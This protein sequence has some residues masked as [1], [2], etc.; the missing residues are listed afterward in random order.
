MTEEVL[1]AQDGIELD[2]S[3]FEGA[4]ETNEPT[5]EQKRF[6]DAE[7]EGE[8][9]FGN[10]DVTPA[11]YSIFAEE[12]ENK[13]AAL[14]QEFFDKIVATDIPFA[15]VEVAHEAL[16]RKVQVFKARAK[17]FEVANRAS[18]KAHLTPINQMELYETIAESEAPIDDMDGE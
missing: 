8:L 11:K 16:K 14:V 13:V 2:V 17:T 4:G 12:Q 6:A 18:N 3:S 7:K 9:D 5:P 10:P 1:D 15:F